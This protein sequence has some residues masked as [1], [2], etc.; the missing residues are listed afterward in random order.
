[1]K[2][3]KNNR[4]QRD[5]ERGVTLRCSSDP[6]ITGTITKQLQS[7]RE[8]PQT[9]RV[10]QQEEETITEAHERDRARHKLTILRDTNVHRCRSLIMFDIRTSS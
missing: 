9:H 5:S 6:Y 2:V 10:K 4:R 3:F 1:M 7:H 8:R